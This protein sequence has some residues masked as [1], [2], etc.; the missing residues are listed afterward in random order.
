MNDYDDYDCDCD[1]VIMM[2]VRCRHCKRG[3]RKGSSGYRTP[4]G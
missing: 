2:A 3:S 4:R 1:D